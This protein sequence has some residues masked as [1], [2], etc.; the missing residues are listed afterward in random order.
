MLNLHK[1]R[2]ILGFLLITFVC[3]SCKNLF[4]YKENKWKYITTTSSSNV[5]T[6]FVDE[7]RV[8]HNKHAVK[9]WTKVI[10]QRLEPIPFEGKEGRA[11]LMVKRIDSS[12][13]YNCDAKTST[14][15]SYQLYDEQDKFIYN[16]WINDPHTN[17]I[18]EGT[19]DEEMYLYLCVAER[20]ETN[21]QEAQ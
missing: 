6:V 17:Y 19:I 20:K 10:F 7:N 15:L 16:Q 21:G 14:V 2:V 8:E 1:T 3:S 18:E 4:E 12:V 5:K 9:A 11:V 13:L